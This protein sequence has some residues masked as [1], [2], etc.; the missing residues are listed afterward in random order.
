MST[1]DP[2]PTLGATDRN[3]T[4]KPAPSRPAR[5]TASLRDE[6]YSYLLR[7]LGDRATFAKKHHRF[8][9]TYADWYLD[10]VAH[11][12]LAEAGRKLAVEIGLG[13]PETMTTTGWLTFLYQQ[14][15]ALANH[16]DLAPLVGKLESI[17]KEIDPDG[18]K[19]VRRDL[20]RITEKHSEIQRWR[21]RTKNSRA[22]ITSNPGFDAKGA[23]LIGVSILALMLAV[24]LGIILV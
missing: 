7:R 5:S 10:H 16:E 20:D 11:E 23:G 12:T 14:R 21:Q 24:A 19:T 17:L 9:D 3:G 1:T 13:A 15:H 6:Q 2:A 8:I 18:R 22:I 4:T